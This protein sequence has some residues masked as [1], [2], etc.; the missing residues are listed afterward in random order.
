MPTRCAWCQEPDPA[1]PVQTE[2]HGIC[3]SCLEHSLAMLPPARR[4][5]VERPARLRWLT[6]AQPAPA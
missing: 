1:R 5:R 3:P 4:P 2:S 6:P